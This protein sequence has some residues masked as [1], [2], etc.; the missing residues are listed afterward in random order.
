MNP[1]TET[2]QIQTSGETRRGLWCSRCLKPACI[3]TDLVIFSPR[4]ISPLG[5]Y[6]ACLDCGLPGTLHRGD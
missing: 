3:A 6:T 2:V 1:P 5:V 4:G